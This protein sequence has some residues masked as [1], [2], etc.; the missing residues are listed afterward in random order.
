MK[1]IVFVQCLLVILIV[2]CKKSE[3][4]TPVGNCANTNIILATAVINST[5]CSTPGNTGSIA[6]NAFG[7]ANFTY[8]INGGASF[9]VSPQFFN[10]AAGSYNVFV[11]DE[12]G[13][14]KSESVTVSN[15][16]GPQFA[17]VKSLIISKCNPCHFPNGLAY[18]DA[19]FDT[20]CKIIEKWNR[21]KARAVDNLPT[22]M[23]YAPL[24]SNEKAIIQAWLD[25]GHGYN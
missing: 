4:I 12:N 18:Q 16:V 9:Q 2:S 7:S 5:P 3:P 20:D 25:G 6:I 19:Q 13:C 1:S 8:S 21:I 14:S 24:P 15:T 23:P 22:S 11:K 17:A 10:L